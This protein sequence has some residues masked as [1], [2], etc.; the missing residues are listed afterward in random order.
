MW[1]GF[2]CT[3][4]QSR[5]GNPQG[6]CSS[7]HWGYC[8]YVL[9]DGVYRLSGCQLNSMQITTETPFLIAP[10]AWNRSIIMKETHCNDVIM[11]A[12]ASQIT[13]FTIVYSAVYSGTDQRKHQSS[14]LLVLWEGNSPLTGE[15]PAQRASNT[16]NVS[17]WR[18]HPGLNLSLLVGCLLYWRRCSVISPL[19]MAAISQTTF[20]NT[21]S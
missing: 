18:R 17:I 3:D 8:L 12:M 7:W 10:D 21:F 19:K 15:L 1:P 14:A 11:S 20:S 5:G 16:E 4:R 13:S 2:L 6:V 9:T